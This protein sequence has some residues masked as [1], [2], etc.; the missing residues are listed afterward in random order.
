MFAMDLQTDAMLSVLARGL[1]DLQ[2]IY[3]VFMVIFILTFYSLRLST[4]ASGSATC[5]D[6]VPIFSDAELQTLNPNL[7]K[8]ISF[9]IPL[10]TP[11]P[12]VFLSTPT[13]RADPGLTPT[14]TKPLP[15][16]RKFIFPPFTTTEGTNEYGFRGN[17]CLTISPQEMIQKRE[18]TAQLFSVLIPTPEAS[19]PRSTR[20]NFTFR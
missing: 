6:L 12:L 19:E 4:G 11:R 2:S 1:E 17:A 16:G 5:L 18:Y 8:L 14:V 7:K 15:T 9:L 20:H 3:Q 13:L 10:A